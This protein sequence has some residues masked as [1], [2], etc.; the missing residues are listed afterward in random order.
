MRMYSVFFGRWSIHLDTVLLESQKPP[1][2]WKKP[3]IASYI[4]GGDLK[5]SAARARY[6]FSAPQQGWRCALH[7][8]A[9]VELL[10]VDIMPE[11]NNKNEST[12]YCKESYKHVNIY[13]A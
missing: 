2:W 8:K 9:E 7:S 13:L 5:M 4:H 3:D 1:F 12:N 11:N 6:F 10:Q